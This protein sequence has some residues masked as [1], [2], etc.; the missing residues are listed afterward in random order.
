M[1]NKSKTIYFKP[2]WIKKDKIHI[3]LDILPKE[4]DIN[5]YYLAVPENFLKIMDDKKRLGKY[6]DRHCALFCENN[7]IHNIKDESKFI[8]VKLADMLK[9]PRLAF[10]KAFF[11]FMNKELTL[12]F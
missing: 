4:E 8:F 10:N 11:S 2:E 7:R 5:D 1:A 12:H 6:Y 9:N 3:P